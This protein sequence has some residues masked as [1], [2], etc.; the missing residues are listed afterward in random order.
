[1]RYDLSDPASAFKDLALD[2]LR[3]SMVRGHSSACD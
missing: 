3:W 2:Q 1:M